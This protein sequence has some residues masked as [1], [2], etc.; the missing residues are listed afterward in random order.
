M[1]SREAASREEGGGRRQETGNRREKEG[2]REKKER[3]GNANK[4][5]YLRMVSMSAKPPCKIAK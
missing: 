4:W 1:A 2:D 5:A 3:G